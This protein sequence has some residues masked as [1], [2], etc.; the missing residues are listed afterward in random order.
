MIE[1]FG[2]S[3]LNTA[4]TAGIRNFTSILSG[5]AGPSRSFATV[6]GDDDG[7]FPR[8]YTSTRGILISKRDLK[9]SNFNNGY[10]FQFNPQ[11]IEDVKQTIWEVR[12]Y[13]GLSYN[14]YV[15]AHGGE[16]IISFQLFLDNTPGSKY[17][18]FRPEAY[19]SKLAQ[20]PTSVGA[21]GYNPR[22]SMPPASARA[23]GAVY[24]QA[25]GEV[26]AAGRT[27]L[28]ND[29]NPAKGPSSLA[30]NGGASRG[31]STTRVDA[32]GILPEVEKIQSFLYPEVAVGEA[33]PKFAQGGIVAPNQ[34]RPPATAVF[35]F[36]P[37]YL[38]GILKNAA[39]KYTLFDKD[40]VPLRGTIDVEFAVYEFE[41]LKPV[42]IPTQQR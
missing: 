28:N 2:N 39:T 9:A 3:V 4:V 13:T 23:N 38:E 18:K 42:P 10:Y 14:D 7:R 5:A 21:S 26:A 41:E 27:L 22:S 24:G 30:Y 16:R 32:R 34:F 11:T 35:A 15:W 36:G 37:I 29:F 12:Q 17:G 33:I 25:V 19:N 8:G 20:E 40:L 1:L 31:Y 6:K